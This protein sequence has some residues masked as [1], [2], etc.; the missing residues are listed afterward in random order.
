MFATRI[1]SRGADTRR[2]RSVSCA[3]SR[4]LLA[5]LSLFVW[6]SLAPCSIRALRASP[7]PTTVARTPQPVST[8]R[9]RRFCVT[10]GYS[11]S[12]VG[13]LPD[14]NWLVGQRKK[15]E[16]IAFGSGQLIDSL[17]LTHGPDVMA[18]SP[19]GRYAATGKSNGQLVVVDLRKRREFPLVGHKD[20]IY[21]L[22]FDRKSGRLVSVAQDHTA[23]V[24]DVARRKARFVIESPERSSFYSVAISPDGRLVAL[25]GYQRVFLYDARRGRLVRSL[26]FDGRAVRSLAFD[27][28]GAHLLAAS[29][30][31]AREYD[32][33]TGTLRRKLTDLHAPLLF[34]PDGKTLLA[35]GTKNALVLIEPATLRVIYRTVLSSKPTFAAFGPK[36]RR[37]AVVQRFDH[38]LDL[39]VL[40][41]LPDLG[42]CVPSSRL[43]TYQGRELWLSL[44][45]FG[46]LPR[47]AVAYGRLVVSRAVD[48]QGNSVLPVRSSIPVMSGFTVRNRKFAGTSRGGFVV[49][50]R[51]NG[52]KPE[53]RR[54]AE[55]DGSIL[56]RVATQSE[57][58]TVEPL[59]AQIGKPLAAPVLT[60]LG[61]RLQ[62]EPSK[63]GDGIVVRCKG[64]CENVEAVVPFDEKGEKRGVSGNVFFGKPGSWEIGKPPSVAAKWKLVITL[65]TK[66]EL[67]R[68]PF[69]LRD[70]KVPSGK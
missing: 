52:L 40:D 66:S 1:S 27:P 37:L 12:G 45:V 59:G 36:G 31:I 68:V 62:I 39:F 56:M 50:L 26:A 42:L 67:V 64:A 70:I 51:V 54:V 14:G 16:T 57:R 4:S 33:K 32:V 30:E 58:L 9:W 23:R 5:S 46:K 25:G 7:I 63:R 18:L 11:F 22:A 28:S 24:W 35:G 69:R 47:D 61:V 44:Q 2:E 19:N 21:G 49:S 65:T 13:L 6:L 53:S 15:L 41:R 55:L 3:L 60:R 43:Y 20:W 29:D 34:S 38:V 10:S 8:A 17:A 48:E